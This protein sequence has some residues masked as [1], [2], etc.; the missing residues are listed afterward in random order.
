MAL[1]RALAVEPRVLLL[2]DPLSG[3]PARER[4]ALRVDLGRLQRD[5]SITT[6]AATRDEVDALSLS[7]RLA[8]MVGGRVLQEGRPEDIY[9]R[10]DSWAVAER[11]G[12]ANLVPVRVVELREVGVIVEAEGGA[13]LPAPSGARAWSPGERG[14]LCL[15]PEALGLE[16]AE[17][18]PGGLPGTVVSYLFEGG[19]QVYQVA[20]AGVTLRVEMPSSAVLARGFKAGDRVKVTLAAETAVLLP[21]ADSA[22][23]LGPRPPPGPGMLW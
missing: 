16:E 9:W 18:A 23:R 8:V 11:V 21:A 15:R 14:T 19:R 2:D 20:A 12:G 5:L 6:L 13:Q 1:A 7:S 4:Q 22:L 10:P 3:L 17:L